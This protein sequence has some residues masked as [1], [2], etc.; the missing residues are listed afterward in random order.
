M[1]GY[2]NSDS[3]ACDNDLNKAWETQPK[4]FNT[5]VTWIDIECIRPTGPPNPT[6]CIFSMGSDVIFVV[7]LISF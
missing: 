7:Q 2:K 1:D 6:P 5:V 4:D 3:S